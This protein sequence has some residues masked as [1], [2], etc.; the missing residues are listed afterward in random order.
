MFTAAD[1]GSATTGIVYQNYPGESPVFSGGVR[2]QNWTNTSGNT[3]KT[4][5]PASTQYFENLFYNGVRRLRPRLGSGRQ[6]LGHV[7]PHRQHRLSADRAAARC[8]AQCQL[9]GLHHRQRMG[10]LRPLPVQP[11]PIRSPERGRTSLLPPAIPAARLP[12]I[13]RI[14]GDIEVLDF[15]QFSTSKLRISCIDTANHIVYLTGPTA[16]SAGQLR[17]GRLH[18]RQSLPGGE[19]GGRAHAAGPVVPGPLRHT[20]D[21]HLPGQPRREPQ[22]RHRHHSATCAGAGGFQP[23]IRDV[24]GTHLRARQ[25]H[26]AAT[27]HISSELEADITAAVSFQNSQHITFDSS[28]VTQTS[29]IGHR[30]HPLP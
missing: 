17:R 5:L 25:L 23:A 19:R 16:I 15:E 22:H 14:A 21:P 29:G 8:R 1:S 26:G 6:S 7:L 24:S 3:W 9:L 28:I 30:I 2:V 12:A 27:G 18:C 10:M 11:L 4:T 20:V 13:R